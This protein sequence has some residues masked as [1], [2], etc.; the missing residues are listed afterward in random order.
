MAITKSQLAQLTIEDL[1]TPD[2]Y[3][4]FPQLKAAAARIARFPEVAQALPDT[5]A[6]ERYRAF[7]TGEHASLLHAHFSPL[8]SADGPSPFP[9]LAVYAAQ[10]DAGDVPGAPN[11]LRV[12]VTDSQVCVHGVERDPDLERQLVSL[13]PP[14]PTARWDPDDQAWFVHPSV[15]DALPCAIQDWIDGRAEQAALAST[16]RGLTPDDRRLL[17]VAIDTIALTAAHGGFHYT[18]EDGAERE[19]DSDQIASLVNK[20]GL[21]SAPSVPASSPLSNDDLALLN[22]VLDFAE[23]TADDMG[24]TWTRGDGTTAEADGPAVRRLAASIGLLRSPR[25]EAELDVAPL[26]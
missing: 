13:D 6:D 25:D 3:A 1:E 16:V 5:T 19:G 23:H 15:A 18:T 22:E 11:G 21:D 7:L 10:L 14:E 24:L 8:H 9:D 20:L 12:T 2:T 17:A 4:L 26:P